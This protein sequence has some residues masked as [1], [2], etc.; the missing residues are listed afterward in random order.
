MKPHVVLILL[1]ALTAQAAPPRARLGARLKT[2]AP[3]A[4]REVVVDAALRNL[5]SV[6]LVVGRVSRAFEY[7]IELVGPDGKAPPLTSY[8]RFAE[9]GRDQARSFETQTI[10]PNGC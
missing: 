10:A 8:G 7:Q 5:S 2:K 6:K 9:R 1:L 3:C 4:G